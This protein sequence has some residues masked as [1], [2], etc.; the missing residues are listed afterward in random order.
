MKRPAIIEKAPCV[1]MIKNTVNGKM[2]IGSS[3]NGNRRYREHLRSLKRGDHLSSRLQRSFDKYGAEAFVFI[4]LKYTEENQHRVEEARI[5][6]LMDSTNREKG[7]NHS[8]LTELG[9]LKHAEETKEKIRK[10]GKGRVFSEESKEKIRKSHQARAAS[11]TDEERKS[12][13][14][15]EKRR[16]P[17]L[18]SNDMRFNSI[19]D[20]ARFFGVVPAAVQKLIKKQRPG[21]VSNNGKHRKLEGLSFK[22]AEKTENE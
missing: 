1:Y 7:Y 6:K 4:V 3:V 11:L 10:A 16:R 22:Y 15:I 17:V 8:D 21:G 18:C 13:A 20:A 12:Q 14:A 2:Y 5:I 19:T 9:V